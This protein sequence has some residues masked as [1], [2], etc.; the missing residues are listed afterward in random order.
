MFAFR[1]GLC[2]LINAFFPEIGLMC[3]CIGMWAD[4]AFR[5]TMNIIRFRSGK[6]LHKR[7]I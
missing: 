6:W 5:S 3:V 2:Y 7:L 1:V 4:W